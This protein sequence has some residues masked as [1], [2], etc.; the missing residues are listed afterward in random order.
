MSFARTGSGSILGIG[1]LFL[2]AT[3]GLAKSLRFDLP[4]ATWIRE[5]SGQ[6]LRLLPS[7]PGDPEDQL[8]LETDKIG[9]WRVERRLRGE[10][11]RCRRKR[12]KFRLGRRG[13]EPL[14]L[15]L[16]KG[17]RTL[18]FPQ[19]LALVLRSPEVVPVEDSI[20]ASETFR[21]GPV[22]VKTPPVLSRAQWGANPPKESYDLHEPEAIVVHHSWWPTTGDYSRRG[23]AETIAAIQTFHQ[24]DRGWNDVGYH[25]LIGPEGLIFQGRPADVVGAH[26]VPNTG[27]VGICMVGNF[28]PLPEGDPLSKESQ[29]SLR[30]LVVYL[31]DRYDISSNE[32][33]GHRNFSS[34]TC[35]G[36]QVY[37]GLKDLRRA[38][39]EELGTTGI[40]S[41]NLLREDAW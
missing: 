26:A 6:S 12:S 1:F 7:L 41:T 25:Y 27:K 20:R 36:D 16:R 40:E 4:K 17:K 9:R 5:S 34:K 14:E 33:Y 29:D 30:E 19:S 35:P 32:L 28:D 13:E 3:S 11:K 39:W 2:L 31:A 38:I 18:E 37:H 22:R 21:A 10:W 24:R 23:G 8:W 15:R